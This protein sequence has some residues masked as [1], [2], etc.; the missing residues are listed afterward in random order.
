M[1]HIKIYEDYQEEMMVYPGQEE[2][3]SIFSTE[4]TNIKPTDALKSEGNYII[5]FS[6]SEGQEVTME[7]AGASDPKYKGENMISPIEII[8][9]SSSDGKEYSTI[10]HYTKVDGGVG[11]YELKKVILKEV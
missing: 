7:I 2:T 11:E 9:G 10:G 4:T 1:K 8:P 3:R 6:N 5:T